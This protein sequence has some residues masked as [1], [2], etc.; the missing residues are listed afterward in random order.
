MI[1]RFLLFA[2][3]C[4]LFSLPVLA[5]EQN[6]RLRVVH[7]S[8]DAPAV[9]VLVDGGKVLASLP[10][11]EYSEYLALPPKSYDIRVNVAGTSTTVLQANPT[12]APGRDYT[13]IA[14]GR[15]SGGSEPLSIL[16]L[17]DNNAEPTPGQVKFRVVHGAPSAPAVD[18]Y[19]TTPFEALDNK[20]P[21][22]SNVPFKAASGYLSVPIQ[23]YQG[24]VTVAG[25]K[26]VAIDTM[27]VPTWGGMIRTIVAVDSTGG[28]APFDVL[29]LPDRN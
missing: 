25:T 14:V 18:V 27:R 2:F 21:A 9:D 29:L 13:V 24:R 6:A 19:V 12:L 28:G 11:R 5:Q 10:F 4:A 17:E 22:L 8:P 16:L 20:T 23:M 1:K 26:T 3:A 7:A 15:V